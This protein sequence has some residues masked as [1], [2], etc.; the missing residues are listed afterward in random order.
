MR[1]KSLNKPKGKRG[2]K[3][4]MTEKIKKEDYA[5]SIKRNAINE[6]TNAN[7][8][9]EVMKCYKALD[10]VNE[11]YWSFAKALYEINVNEYWRT[12]CNSVEEFLGKFEISKATYYRQIA[13]AK[14]LNNLLIPNGYTELNFDVTTASLFAVLKDGAQAFIDHCKTDGIHIELM[15]KEQVETE[16][17]KFM[18]ALDNAVSGNEE[19]EKEEKKEKEVKP[20]I[21]LVGKNTFLIKYNGKEWNITIKELNAVMK[22]REEKKGE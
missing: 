13:A 11:G 4:K 21:E 15:T 6:I 2:D 1:L 17:K 8:K 10:K 3:T 7:L 20:R 5:V 18:K 22:G 12:D 16:I 9:K 19:T 14:M